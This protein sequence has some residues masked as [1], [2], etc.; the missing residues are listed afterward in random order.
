MVPGIKEQLSSRFV[1]GICWNSPGTFT[2]WWSEQ[3]LQ[4]ISPASSNHAISHQSADPS[5]IRSCKKILT[6]RKFRT[7]LVSSENCAPQ[8]S[9]VYPIFPNQHCNFGGIP[10]LGHSRAAPS[11]NSKTRA[12]QTNLISKQ[13]LSLYSAQMGPL[14]ALAQVGRKT[15]DLG[16]FSQSK[17]NWSRASNGG[18]IVVI[19]SEHSSDM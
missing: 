18:D 11:P 17:N 5:P 16:S 2:I 12:G 6:Q 14:G 4:P 9:A 1:V 19:P 3:V 8:N 7:H 13:W 10:I 15:G